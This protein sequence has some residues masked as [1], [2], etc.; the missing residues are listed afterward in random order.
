MLR[1]MFGPRLNT[2]FASRWRA[3]WFSG[4]ILLLAYCSIPEAPADD[5]TAAFDQAEATAAAKQAIDDSGLSPNDRKKAE[6]L[7]KGMEQ[8][9]K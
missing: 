1:C 6:E 8:L 5:K 7:L 4:S 9:S 3:L 2:V